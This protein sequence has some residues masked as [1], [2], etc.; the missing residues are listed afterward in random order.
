MEHRPA[1]APE[2]LLPAI[3]RT[4]RR[5]AGDEA[6]NSVV[7]HLLYGTSGQAV[8]TG[9]VARVLET[10]VRT[11]VRR[12]RFEEPL[13]LPWMAETAGAPRF[14]P[15]DVAGIQAYVGHDEGQARQ[16]VVRI[17]AED[18]GALPPGEVVHRREAGGPSCTARGSKETEPT[19]WIG[20]TPGT[21]PVLEELDDMWEPS[22]GEELEDEDRLP[23]R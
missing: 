16:P 10:L 1:T 9:F 15:D 21:T 13:P 11:G 4:L 14:G 18:Q 8:P 19:P 12:I 22:L 20:S 2:V 3:Q 6:V 7:V 5:V 23:R 17:A